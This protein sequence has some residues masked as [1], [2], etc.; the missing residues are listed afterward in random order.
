MDMN[1]QL[2]LIVKACATAVMVLVAVILL[3]SV[4][5]ELVM[6]RV[7]KWLC[8]NSALECTPKHAK[9]VQTVAAKA[10]SWIRRSC[11]KNVKV[12]RLNARRNN[13]KSLWTRVLPTEKKSL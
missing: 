6:D 12:R 9:S 1:F 5:V 3:L 11:A 8:N 13:T 10:S 7:S 2:K 4:N